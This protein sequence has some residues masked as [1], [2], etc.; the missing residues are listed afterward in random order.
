[1]RDIRRIC[2]VAG[3]VKR[4]VVGSGREENKKE[5]EVQVIGQV[6]EMFLHEKLY[7]NIINN[8]LSEDN[9]TSSLKKLIANV[10]Y[11]ENSFN[12]GIN[13]QIEISE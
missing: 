10:F 6:M 7:S 9:L 2:K 12:L 8:K 3:V 13:H 11:N 4:R 5:R 1:M